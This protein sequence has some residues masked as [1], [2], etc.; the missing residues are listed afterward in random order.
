[1][2]GPDAKVARRTSVNHGRTRSQSTLPGWAS[3]VALVGVVAALT[4]AIRAHELPLTPFVASARKIAS[5]QV[6][7]L[8]ASALVVDKPFLIGLIAFAVLAAATLQFCGTRTFW[9]AAAAGHAGSTLLVYAIIGATRLAD[10]HI[11]ARA[12]ATP[13]FGVSAMQGAWVGAIA[14]TAWLWA[15]ANRRNRGLVVAGVCAIAGVGW[16]LHPDPSIL[17]TEH[18]FAFLIGCGIVSWRRFAPVRT[19]ARSR[20]VPDRRSASQR[21]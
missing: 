7:I 13:D 9:L 1:M 19:E 3:G 11:F 5:G 20:L 6:W 15:G 14:A 12:A 16:W 17:T 10:P 8:P 21:T 4:V 18:L 2:R